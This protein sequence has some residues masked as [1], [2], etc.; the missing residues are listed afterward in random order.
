MHP[1]KCRDAKQLAEVLP[2]WECWARDLK[3]T[4]GGPVDESTKVCSLDQLL[5]ADDN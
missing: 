3:T 1:T 4:R 2:L 5:P